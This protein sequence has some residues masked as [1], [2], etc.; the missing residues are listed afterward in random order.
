MKNTLL[1]PLLQNV[2]L[3]LLLEQLQQLLL[4]AGGGG[5]GEHHRIEET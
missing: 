5:L 4:V 1:M 3:L 2:Q